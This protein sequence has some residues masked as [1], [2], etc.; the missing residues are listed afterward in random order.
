[1]RRE[2]RRLHLYHRREVL[3][4]VNIV[5]TGLFGHKELLIGC[6]YRIKQRTPLFRRIHAILTG[7]HD[8]CRTGDLRGIDRGFVVQ[9]FPDG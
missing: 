8:Q 5:M 4:A 1:M 7:D 6:G 9:R 3:T 2:P